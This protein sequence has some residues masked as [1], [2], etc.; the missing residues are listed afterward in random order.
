MKKKYFKEYL[1]I[2]NIIAQG[3]TNRMSATNLNW[4][5]Q[6][7]RKI[8]YRRFRLATVWT[9]S[10]QSISDHGPFVLM[11]FT[12]LSCTLLSPIFLSNTFLSKAWTEILTILSNTWVQ[13]TQHQMHNVYVAT[14][15][16]MMPSLHLQAL[17]TIHTARAKNIG[18]GEDYTFLIENSC[19]TWSTFQI[20]SCDKNL[21]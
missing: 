6:I 14:F 13:P 1:N 21:F 16:L 9:D 15:V 11:A 5:V 12:W 19:A 3:F 20:I 17:Q 8:M 7:P 18:C 10:S 4:L 2:F